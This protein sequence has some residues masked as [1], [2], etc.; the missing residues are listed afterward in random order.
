MRS[1]LSAIALSSRR[2]QHRAAT[3]HSASSLSSSAR[4]LDLET[5]A[6]AIERSAGRSAADDDIAVRLAALDDVDFA[7]DDDANAPADTGDFRDSCERENEIEDHFKQVVAD[8]M[9]HSV[10][11]DILRMFHACGDTMFTEH[12]P[13]SIEWDQLDEAIAVLEERG[14]T[15]IRY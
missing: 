3:P 12:F 11:G 1:G 5:H 9:V 14:F 6:A 13:A 7:G 2:A 8:G 15:I 10:L 4:D